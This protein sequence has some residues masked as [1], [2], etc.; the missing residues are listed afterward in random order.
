[1]EK[2]IKRKL[3]A[4]FHI[5]HHDLELESEVK[6]LSLYMTKIVSR[7]MSNQDLQKALFVDTKLP[8]EDVDVTVP[9]NSQRESREL[10]TDSVSFLKRDSMEFL[11]EF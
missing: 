7:V 8:E 6:A 2:S 11:K 4:S 10:D 1:V 9:P 3:E 5:F